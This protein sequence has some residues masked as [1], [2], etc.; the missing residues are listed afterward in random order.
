MGLKNKFK[1]SIHLPMMTSFLC[2][3]T[4]DPCFQL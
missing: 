4:N 1:I 3:V 2:S